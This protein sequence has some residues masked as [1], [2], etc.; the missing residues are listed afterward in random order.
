MAVTFTVGTFLAFNLSY[1][2]CTQSVIT[3]H[4]PP[5]DKL[6]RPLKPPLLVTGFGDTSILIVK[7]ISE[8][9]PATNQWRTS[10]GFGGRSIL[11]I[12]RSLKE[13]SMLLHTG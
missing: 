7:R 13:Q 3:L 1:N 8:I 6:S 9:Y 11:R 2:F 5:R 10:D 12:E 4:K